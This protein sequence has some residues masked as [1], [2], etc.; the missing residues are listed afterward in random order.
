MK[1]LKGY[2]VKPLKVK[3]GNVV[4][5]DDGTTEIMP[6]QVSCEAYG[7]TWNKSSSTCMIR[8]YESG[9]IQLNKK[10]TEAANTMGGNRNKLGG[11]VSNSAV[12]GSNNRFEG[13]NKNIIINGNKNLVKSN[14]FDSAIIS[15]SSNTLTE[16]VN[17]S[18]VI[19]GVGAVSIRDNETVIGGFYHDGIE[20]TN[21]TLNP[22]TT[23]IS[24][25]AMQSF[26]AI[27]STPQSEISPLKTQDGNDYIK[28]HPNSF[29]RFKAECIVSGSTVGDTSCG[30]MVGQIAVDSSGAATING[31]EYINDTNQGGKGNRT[32]YLEI[33]NNNLRFVTS[34]SS[35]TDNTVSA[36]VHLTE[37]IHNV[38]FAIV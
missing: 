5:T 20:K 1:Y 21:S 18:T 30:T 16:D 32:F 2:L 13:G 3:D 27:S 29:V 4:F 8:G 17:N 10:F 11:F 38:G 26:I 33:V 9:V 23:Q 15:G 12:Y 36:S 22:F 34:A 19:S 37:C 7:Y 24:L 6:S 31:Q 28:L 14:V 35:S 25:F